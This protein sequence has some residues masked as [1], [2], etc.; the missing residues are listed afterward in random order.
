MCVMIEEITLLNLELTAQKL[1]SIQRW[2]D[3]RLA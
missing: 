2:E 1:L 3:W